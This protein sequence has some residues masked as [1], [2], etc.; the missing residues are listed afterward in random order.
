[1]DSSASETH[2]FGAESEMTFEEVFRFAY[3]PIFSGLLQSLRDELG[4]EGFMELVKGAIDRYWENVGRIAAEQAS[5]NDLAAFSAA[6]S[7]VG[8]GLADPDRLWE[9]ALTIDVIEETDHTREIR[10]T[11]CLWAKT[12][13]ELNL[14]DIGYATI[15]HSDYAHC[16]GFNPKMR[17]TRTKTLMQGDD[18]CD[19]RWVLEE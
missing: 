4:D 7:P 5:R 1:M 2:K 12:M 14:A 6:E 11:E 17:L 10:I 13:R 18:C 19:H 9:H 15:C 8:A 16:Q 3:G